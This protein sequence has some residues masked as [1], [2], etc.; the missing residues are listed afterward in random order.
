M[1]LDSQVS[2]L[3]GKTVDLDT[4]QVV[5]SDL[6]QNETDLFLPRDRAVVQSIADE[7]VYPVD[8]PTEPEAAVQ[9]LCA[10]VRETVNPLTSGSRVQGEQFCFFTSDGHIA[11]YRVE[12]VNPDTH[13][14]I[15]RIRVW[16]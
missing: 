2:I 14:V 16:R 5:T 11:W 1:I 4:G 9:E 3:P 13:Q 12:G 10:K 8:G 6:I 15:F 7:K